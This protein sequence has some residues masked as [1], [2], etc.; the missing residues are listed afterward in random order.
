MESIINKVLPDIRFAQEVRKC[1]QDVMFYGFAVMK[2]GYGVETE[3]MPDSESPE[4]KD[5]TP[6]IREEGVFVMRVSPLDFG[7]DPV[8]TST[9]DARYLIHR[10]VKPLDEIKDNDLYSGADDLQAEMP[11]DFKK[12]LKDKHGDV[13]GEFA[14]IFEYHDLTKNKI[15]TTGKTSKKFL[16]DQDNPHEFK[17][18]H[19]V[20]LKLA[21]DNDEFRG[22]Q[23]IGMIE[24]E[25]IALN[26]TVTK[27]IKHLDIFPGQVICEQGAMDEDE[28]RNLAD[29]EQGTILMVQ[30]GAVS[31][32][33]VIKS[34]PLPMGSDYFNVAKTM[35]SLIDLVFGIPDWQ[36]SGI[37]RRKTA[38]EAT[39]EQADTSIRREYFLNYVSDF[40]KQIIVKVASLIQQYYDRE[41]EIRVEGDTGI[42]YVKWTNEDIAGEYDFDF[43]V[44]RG[45]SFPF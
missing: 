30:P 45:F 5:E 20:V 2:V 23:M 40:V 10:V 26:D 4:S 35:Q 42:E 3:S 8:A 38:T 41:R 11:E 28:R 19:F 29:G 24:D 36:R 32:N 37:N 33:R 17:G 22:I 31:Q 13:S 27:M 25:A 21:G 16:R 12:R 39:F 18:S 7:F 14:T 1:V 6:R 43:D 44:H 34:Q 9:D 15:Y